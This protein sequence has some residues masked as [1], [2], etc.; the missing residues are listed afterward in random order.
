MFQCV[1]YNALGLLF[2][3]RQRTEHVTLMAGQ[4]VLDGSGLLNP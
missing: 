1:Q 3:C 2:A 4:P